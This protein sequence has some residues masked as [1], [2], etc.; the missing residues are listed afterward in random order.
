M[1]L[2]QFNALAKLLRLR[3]G[4]AETAAK[5]VFVDGM[6]QADA[7]RE[8]GLTTQSVGNVCARVRKGAELAKEAAGFPTKGQK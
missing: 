3:Q 1:D 7:A 5:L 8:V 6:R 4:R 2:E